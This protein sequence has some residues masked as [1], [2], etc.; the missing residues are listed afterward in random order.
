M[1][2]VIE[3]ERCDAPP[4]WGVQS[5]TGQSPSLSAEQKPERERPFFG[6]SRCRRTTG[7]TRTLC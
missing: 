3:F 2:W 7:S 5:A 4:Q 6:S 1:V